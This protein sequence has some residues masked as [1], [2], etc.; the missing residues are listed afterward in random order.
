MYERRTASCLA[1][2]GRFF[3]KGEAILP[4]QYRSPPLTYLMPHGRHEP[5]KSM[6]TESSGLVNMPVQIAD[7]LVHIVDLL[8]CHFSLFSSYNLNLIY[9]LPRAVDQA[10]SGN[11]GLHPPA[12]ALDTCNS[13]CPIGTRSPR[14]T[15]HA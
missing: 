7:R 9:T 4:L 15:D 11:R 12:S 5:H 2:R 14:I 8:C 13:I 1:R 10:V 3:Q 6:T